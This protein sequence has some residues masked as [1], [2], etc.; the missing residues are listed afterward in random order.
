MSNVMMRGSPARAGDRR[1]ADDAARRAREDGAHRLVAGD[2]RPDE[3]AA[4]LHDAEAARRRR[5]EAPEMPRHYRADVGV[6]DARREALVLAVLAHQAVGQGDVQ[7]GPCER[8]AEAALV[9]R[10]CPAVEEADRHR[11]RAPASRQ[12]DRARHLARR[13]AL[14]DATARPARARVR[15][16]AARA[17]RAGQGAAARA[18]TA[19]AH[20][21]ADLEDV[22]EPAVVKRTTRAPRRSRSALVA[23]V[24]P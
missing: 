1:G 11:L 17:A 13:Q 23:T 2:A 5:P 20:L 22:L 18:H 6:H 16:S 12:H 7:S 19:P 8:P 10:R 4:R 24:E 15:R 14:L 9:R 3:P 21:A